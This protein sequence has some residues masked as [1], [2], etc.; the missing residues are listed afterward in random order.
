MV[1]VTLIGIS[2]G[3]RVPRYGMLGQLLSMLAT[4]AIL[5]LFLAVPTYDALQNTSYLNAYFDMVSAITTT[6]LSLIHISE[7]TRPY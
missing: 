3:N 4:F 6:G 1:F 2:L 5:P 7:P